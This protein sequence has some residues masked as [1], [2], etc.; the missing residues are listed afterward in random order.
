LAKILSHD[1]D[2]IVAGSHGQGPV[3]GF[4]LGGFTIHLLKVAP[5]PVLVV[6]RTDPY[7]RS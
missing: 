2:L 7:D 1:A 3:A 5:R 6:P 4:F